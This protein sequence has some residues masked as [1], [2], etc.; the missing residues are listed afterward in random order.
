[1]SGFLDDFSAARMIFV[2]PSLLCP[3]CEELKPSL[4]PERARRHLSKCFVHAD[5]RSRRGRSVN[6]AVIAA[7]NSWMIL[8]AGD[9]LKSVLVAVGI[10]ANPGDLPSIVD[11]SRN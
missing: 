6:W 3:E 11:R 4:A 1:V 8:V 2:I 10:H 5:S 7:L 9:H